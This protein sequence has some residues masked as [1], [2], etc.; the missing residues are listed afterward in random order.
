MGGDSMGLINISQL[1]FSYESS[2]DNI[3]ENVS[4]QIDTDWKLGF[5]GRNGR[6]KTTFLK[7]LL[8]VYEY[9]GK[10]TGTTNFEYF[11]FNVAEEQVNTIEVIRTIN[12]QY[13]L[14]EVQRELSLLEVKEDVWERPFCTLS[15]G[16]QCKVLLAT[17]FLQ[18][19][20][21]LLIDEPTNH[22]DNKARKVL[23]K[24][25]K[26][27]SGFILIS[28]DRYFLD[29]CVDHV[30]SI[31]KNNIEIQKG[32]FSSWYYNKKL[33]DNFELAQ[34]E[35]LKK[36][37]AR[38][39]KSAQQ[40]A[41][42]STQKEKSKVGAYDKGYVGHKAAK[43]MQRS[44]AIE[45]RKE[46][47]WLAKSKLLKNIDNVEVLK[48][49]PQDY[50]QKRLITGIDLSIFYQ[51]KKICAGVNL[52]VEQ[53]DRIALQGK[54]GSGKSSLLK[55]ICGEKIDFRGHLQIGSRLIISYVSQDTAF[56]VGSLEDFILNNKIETT[57][58]KAI[59]R[60]LDFSRQQFT[61]DLAEFSDGQ[62][63][64]VLLA[65]SLCESAHIYIWDEPLNFIDVLSR[66]QI[67]QLILEYKPT[68]LF[69]EH[70][71]SFTEN[72]ATKILQLP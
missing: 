51:E 68:L 53:G 18:A 12:A 15:K 25:L 37:I 42:W 45:A 28:H 2:Y 16:E 35:H 55:V 58:F 38:L 13:A 36:D 5:I 48:L 32:N 6:G 7:L 11:P 4:L 10:I 29:Q 17:L 20:K 40:A 59:L 1:T 24:Y 41:R 8:G 14:W 23:G 47:A 63:K 19:D 71:Q 60:K 72:I 56:L 34:N 66:I 65:K 49:H 44:K 26:S 33:Q 62:K 69:V 67:E 46:E 61:K 31:N 27:K 50:Y 52:I 57:L 70:D 54:N 43:M 39:K 64:K 9:S 22:L 30:L 3:F 21:F